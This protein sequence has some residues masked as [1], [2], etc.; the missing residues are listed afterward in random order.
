MRQESLSSEGKPLFNLADGNV[1]LYKDDSIRGPEFPLDW[2]LS[3]LSTA[4]WGP[5]TRS[6]PHSAR[7]WRGS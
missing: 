2:S 6:W 3:G 7:K 1:Q 4:C 5:T